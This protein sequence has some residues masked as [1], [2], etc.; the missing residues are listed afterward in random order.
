MGSVIVMLWL[1]GVNAT[2]GRARDIRY[3]VIFSLL[4][5]MCFLKPIFFIRVL[6]KRRLSVCVY[7]WGCYT[8]LV[9]YAGHVSPCCH[10]GFSPKEDRYI[11]L[12]HEAPFSHLF[13]YSGVFT[14]MENDTCPVQR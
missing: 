2:G 1:F 8:L 13:L 4:W 11:F 3:I 10:F 12:G 14:W 7:L 6:C 9:V 5:S